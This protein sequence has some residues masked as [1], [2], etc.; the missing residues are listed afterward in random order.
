MN[1][2][3]AHNSLRLRKG[4]LRRRTRTINS[5]RLRP[6]PGKALSSVAEAALRSSTSPTADRASAPM[7]ESPMTRKHNRRLFFVEQRKPLAVLS[8]NLQSAPGRGA[9]SLPQS[10]VDVIERRK[11]VTDGFPLAS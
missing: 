4:P 2:G 1:R 5:A 7:S 9:I 6:N 3:N 8:Q 11:V 10:R